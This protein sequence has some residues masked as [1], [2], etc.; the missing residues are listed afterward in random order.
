MKKIFFIL[1]FMLSWVAEARPKMDQL[2][3]QED[4][5]RFFSRF[6][7]RV[8]QVYYDPAMYRTTKLGEL[9]LRE[10]LLY[11][12]EALKI[13]TGP[14]PEVNLLDMIVFIKLNK[15]VVRDYWTPKYYGKAGN[16]LW[17]AF[18]TSEDDIESIAKKIMD[19]KQLKQVDQLVRQWFKDN[20][21]QFRVEKIRIGDFSSV[22]SKVSQGQGGIF[23][24]LSISN[25]L[26]GTK[27]T[28]KA[29]DQMVLVAN[30]GIFLAQHLPGLIRLQARLGSNEVMD[31]VSMRMAKSQGMWNKLNETKPIVN[32][33]SGLVAQLNELVQNSKELS[34]SVN[35]AVPQGV[36][37]SDDLKEIHGTVN[38]LNSMLMQ[39]NSNGLRRTEVLREIKQEFR[40]SV[41]FLAMVIVLIA[42]CVSVFWWGGAYLVK[43][44]EKL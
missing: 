44:R 27:D 23:E 37:W 16:K 19:E 28:V 5:Q 42:L 13:A 10:Y 4:V 3:L 36:N 15:V 35:K 6:V 30:R 39:I 22:A 33:L 38:T 11:E 25:L 29:V 2:E 21:G 20:P 12:S 41:W 18:K 14:Y 24:T 17:K 43:K 9:S 32:D 34:H 8:V 40:S 7:E 1:L 31:D 26:V